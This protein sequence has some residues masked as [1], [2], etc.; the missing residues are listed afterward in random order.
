[1]KPIIK[2]T[3]NHQLFPAHRQ[4]LKKLAEL[5]HE[6]TISSRTISYYHPDI[7]K[8]ETKSDLQKLKRGDIHV[9]RSNSKIF[10]RA[11]EQMKPTPPALA[12]VD[13]GTL[14]KE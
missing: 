3:T 5:L 2:I 8:M 12:S 14:W 4:D 11:L 10:D 9:I 1:M 6:G 13:L 7:L